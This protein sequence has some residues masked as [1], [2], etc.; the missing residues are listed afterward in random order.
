MQVKT[1]LQLGDRQTDIL[2]IETLYLLPRKLKWKEETQTQFETWKKSLSYTKTHIETFTC[3]VQN[4]FSYLEQVL[5]NIF[6]SWLCSGFIFTYEKYQIVNSDKSVL[7]PQ[8]DC[9]IFQLDQICLNWYGIALKAAPIVSLLAQL[10]NQT[11]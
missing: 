4:V 9:L 3:N 2:A 10:T 8:P 11:K 5:A 1:R 7:Y 6:I